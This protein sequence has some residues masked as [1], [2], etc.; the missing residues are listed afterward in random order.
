ME[1]KTGRKISL[2]MFS[3]I[4][5]YKYR[6]LNHELTVSTAKIAFW[7]VIGNFFA[8]GVTVLSAPIFTRILSK[9]EFGEFSNFTSWEGIL[10]V[11]VTLDLGS[12][13]A[14]AKYD[15]NSRINEYLSSIL[16]FSNIVTISIYICIEIN[17]RYFMELFSIEIEYIRILFLYLLFLPAFSFLQIKHRIYRKYK[18]F[19]FFS[20]SSA[21]IRTTLSIVLVLHMEN[22]ILGR[23]CGYLIPVTIL[24]F[25][26]WIV[27]LADGKR[28]S[29]NCVRYGCK[30]S[31]PLMPHALAGIIL[32]NSDRIMITH[33]CGS[34]VTALYSLAYTVSTMTAL[35][36]TSMNQAWTPWLYDHM[37]SKDKKTIRKNSK[38]YISVFMG[39]LAGVYL[40]APEL[41]WILGGEQY[42]EAKYVMPPVILACSFQFIYGMYVNIEIFAKQTFTIS[43]GTLG[44]AMLNLYLNQWLIS[45]YGY[46]AAAYTTTV[47]Y[48]VLL[49]FHYG[50]VRVFIKENADLYDKK[51]IV[52]VILL[53]VML[54]CV[55]LVLYK[56]DFFRYLLLFAY[57][58][59]VVVVIS[60][61]QDQIRYWIGF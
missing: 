11:L 27:V 41:I 12:S 13:I 34:E 1:A 57:I 52:I 26:L 24:H 10:I 58:V 21:I 60:R 51:F 16:I 20:V 6:R 36:W 37:D 29:W 17:Q 3:F 53:M 59:A 49:L 23:I 28:L 15:Y 19:V 22:K 45:R 5:D 14:R 46:I 54:S 2:I 39:L 9:S 35:L 50:I 38:I 47:G 48:F 25:I 44:A 40:I 31:I 32:G 18:F 56:Y 4:K 33:Y 7:Y 61:H 43:F 42:Y 8:K 30:I 55:S